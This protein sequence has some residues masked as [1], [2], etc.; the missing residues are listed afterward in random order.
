[1]CFRLFALAI[2]TLVMTMPAPGSDATDGPVV[3]LGASVIS[4]WK[5]LDPEYFTAHPG[6]LARGRN[7]EST[8]GTLLRVSR[9]ILPLRPSVVVIMPSG[10]DSRFGFTDEESLGNL[11]AIAD[12]A[13][14]H[15]SRVV[16]LGPAS[17]RPRI[18][19]MVDEYAKGEGIPFVSLSAI[20]GPDGGQRPDLSYD[21]VHPNREGYRLVEPMVTMAIEAVRAAPATT[22]TRAH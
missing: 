13:R 19:A 11:R 10:N 15:G 5:R 7:G 21:G 8:R 3:F 14:S 2:V 4:Y 6:Y 18:E 1:M 16:I 12:A 17:P 20:H 22:S 9:D